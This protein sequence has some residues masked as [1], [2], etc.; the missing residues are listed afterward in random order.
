M[1]EKKQ[2]L[3]ARIPAQE[4]LR[5]QTPQGQLVSDRQLLVDQYGDNSPQVQSFDK[6]V[7]ENQKGAKLTD[8]SS[9]R[10]QY[11][12]E[13][14]NF[15]VVRDAF[16]KIAASSQNPSAAGDLALIF[17]FMKLLD[18]TSV[19]RESEFATA[20]NAANVPERIRSVYNRVI[21][22]ERLTEI[23]R[24]D[25]LT[26][27]EALFKTQ[28]GTQVQL[29]DQIRAIAE[30][31]GMNPENVAP[32]LVGQD[33]RGAIPGT[34]LPPGVPEGSQLIGR[35]KDN[36]PIYQAPDGKKYVAEPD[37][38]KKNAGP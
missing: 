28:V 23:Q 22:G 9:L 11:F 30:R 20:A 7:Q 26:Q 10:G 1:E 17:N 2:K 4:Q 12:Q 24:T 3:G 32:D 27:S 19:V 38:E 37:K 31:T 34:K 33:Y 14:K 36:Y 16:N 29:T 5:P 25:F 21:S 13:S 8:E 15:V 35:T 18:P 6:Y